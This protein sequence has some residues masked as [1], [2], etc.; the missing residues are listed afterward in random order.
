MCLPSCCGGI[1]LCGKSSINKR[2]KERGVH[3]LAIRWPE[4]PNSVTQNGTKC[5]INKSYNQDY[6]KFNGGMDGTTV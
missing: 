4:I 5:L 2:T 1:V 3:C 6:D